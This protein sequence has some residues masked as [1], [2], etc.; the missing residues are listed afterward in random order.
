M[1]AVHDK[2]S[3]QESKPGTLMSNI[4]VP[5]DFTGRSADIAN[6]AVDLAHHFHSKVMLLHVERPVQ[7]DA[8]WTAEAV[9][10]A[11]QRMDEFMPELRTDPDV[12]RIVCSHSD[13]SAEILR[14]ASETGA[15]LIVMPTHGYGAI[16][17]VL[18]GSIVDN[19]LRK[20]SCPVW[21]CARL[22]PAPPAQWLE[23]RRILCAV[24]SVIEGPRV[25][26]WASAL[27]SELSAK[28]CVA[29][30]RKGLT[31]NRE[32]MDHLRKAHRIYAEV[33]VEAGNIPNVLRGAASRMQANLLIIDRQFRRSSTESG[34][35]MYQVVRQSPCP[36]VYV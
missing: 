12:R 10:W 31:D 25:L 35:D 8:Y 3:Y 2:V 28:L 4:L 32:E 30:S 16:R 17:R 15:D 20:A 23:P 1:L 22:R 7:G 13:V 6:S 24:D 29:W 14:V 26:S 19:V 9:H 11:E 36:V 5:V 27:A 21:T 34:L 18:L 33:G